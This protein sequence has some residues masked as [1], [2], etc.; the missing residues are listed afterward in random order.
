M[1]G[2]DI[3]LDKAD[4]KPPVAP[5]APLWVS[6]KLESDGAGTPGILRSHARDL[7]FFTFEPF[8][9]ASTGDKLP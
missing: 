8:A 4:G 6:L 7:S 9:G 3:W 2:A 5:N 1:S